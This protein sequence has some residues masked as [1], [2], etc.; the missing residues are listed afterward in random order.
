[1]FRIGGDEFAVILQGKGYETMHD[2]MNEFNRKVEEN[3]KTGSVVVSIGYSVLEKDDH[4][5]QEVFARADQ[6]MY[7]RKREL[8]A[9]GAKTR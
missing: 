1:V 4:S 7:E 6:M 8:K 2:V 3:I 5:L 9:M